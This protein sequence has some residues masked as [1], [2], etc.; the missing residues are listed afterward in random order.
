MH[1]SIHDLSH[2][3][4]LI[5]IIMVI[6]VLPSQGQLTQKDWNSVDQ[7]APLETADAFLNQK[8]KSFLLKSIDLKQF[9]RKLRAKTLTISLPEPD[10]NYAEYYIQRNQVVADEVAEY[11]TI[12]TFK[13][14]KIDD[15]TTLI[16]CDISSEGFHASVLSSKNSYFIEPYSR[17]DK[18][19]H[20]AYYRKDIPNHK[21]KCG[22]HD[23]A[24][25]Q[26]PEEA[27]KMRTITEP[28]KETYRL[29]LVASGV[30]TAIRW[31]TL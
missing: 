31:F 23:H 14:Y 28:F 9:E 29:A 11:Y 2:R 5:M 15:P 27:V 19:I 16:A 17:A 20:I 24:K 1:L 22:A 18:A 10:G 3:M 6:A 26:L 8:P 21:I 7:V 4:G 25:A 30:W 12:Q 13:G